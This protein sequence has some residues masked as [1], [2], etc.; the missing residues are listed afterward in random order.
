MT[1]TIP[2]DAVIPAAP[3]TVR[4]TSNSAN[5]AFY[6]LIGNVEYEGVYVTI[7]RSDD[8]LYV[9]QERPKRPTRFHF[10]LHVHNGKRRWREMRWVYEPKS[11]PKPGNLP[12]ATVSRQINNFLR[13]NG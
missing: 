8:Y 9:Q 3:V 11:A 7:L 2:R 4:H 13:V 12:L 6:R 5:I 10:S 1:T